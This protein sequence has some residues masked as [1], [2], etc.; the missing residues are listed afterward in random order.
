MQFG[1]YELLGR[2]ATG[3]SAHIFLAGQRG[4]HGYERLLCLKTLMPERAADVE[5]V[6]HFAAEAELASN[7]RHPNCVNIFDLGQERGAFYISMEYIA[8]ETLSSLLTTWKSEDPLPAPAM[9]SILASACDGLHYAHELCAPDGHAYNLIH[10]DVS[11]QN[12]MIA[13]SGQTKV[14]DFGIAKAEMERPET[15]TGI[16]KGKVR[17]MSPE[18]ILSGPL[19]RRSDIYSLGL[20][21]FECLTGRMLFENCSPAQIQYKMLHERVPRV[22]DHVPDVDPQLDAIC[23][24]A[25]QFDANGRYP[26]AYVMGRELRTYLKRVAFPTGREPIAALMRERFGVRATDRSQLIE[27]LMETRVEVAEIRTKLGVRPVMELDIFGEHPHEVPK[28]VFDEDSTLLDPNEVVHDSTIEEAERPPAMSGPQP[29][30]PPPAPPAR[31]ISQPTLEPVSALP[32]VPDAESFADQT[33]MSSDADV[34]RPILE[35]DK[36][37]EDTKRLSQSAIAV[38]PPSA[39]GVSKQTAFLLWLF[40]LLL[41]A[42]LGVIGTLLFLGAW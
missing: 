30:P 10:R 14:L 27:K 40:G 4:A 37:T 11:P 26:T 25:L 9:V 34:T 21:L 8:G 31:V 36:P 19:D 38:P 29:R 17:Y 41:G 23:Y 13:Y 32:L 35:L 2:L 5:F 39:V 24:T 20:V 1:S 16:V 15:K 3:G 28:D 42:A 6:Q 7:L 33:R 18:Q 12:I 22:R